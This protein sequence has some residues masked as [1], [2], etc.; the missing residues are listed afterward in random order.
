M[1]ERIEIPRAVE[2]TEE[3]NPGVAAPTGDVLIETLG[4]RPHEV[5]VIERKDPSQLYPFLAECTCG[6]QARQLT[7]DM[8]H[9]YAERHAGG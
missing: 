2:K 5:K 1:S 4:K 8:I 3:L 6:Y 7:K 9:R